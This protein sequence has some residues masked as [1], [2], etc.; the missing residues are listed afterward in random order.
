[1]TS[2]HE[3]PRV[4]L[5]EDDPVLRRWVLR[6]AEDVDVTIVATT[7]QWARALEEIVEHEADAVVID[8]ATVGRVGVRLIHALRRLAPNC[9]V[10]VISPLRTIDLAVTEAGASVVTGPS[11]L[12]PIAAGLAGLRN[13]KHP[14]V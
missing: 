11:D 6:L 3:P 2:R 8:L 12:R 13:A 9:E 1:V 5:C 7:D 10:M 4:V 14:V